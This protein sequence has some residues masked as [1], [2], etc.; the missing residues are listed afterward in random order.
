MRHH[1]C[2]DSLYIQG[3]PSLPGLGDTSSKVPC[4]RSTPGL[5][6]WPAREQMSESQSQQQQRGLKGEDKKV[7]LERETAKSEASRLAHSWLPHST[8]FSVS[9]D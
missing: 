6:P 7:D 2:V 4:F 1:Y 5:P 3:R 8:G 9:L